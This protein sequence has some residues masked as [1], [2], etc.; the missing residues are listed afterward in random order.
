MYFLY[1][2]LQIQIQILL[3]ALSIIPA[4]TLF[5]HSQSFKYGIP[6][7]GVLDAQ[8]KCDSESWEWSWKTSLMRPAENLYEGIVIGKRNYKI[9]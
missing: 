5:Q 3:W 6:I 1:L 2:L 7:Q 9:C 8:Q 4:I